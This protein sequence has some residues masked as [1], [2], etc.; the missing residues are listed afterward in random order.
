[1]EVTL[2]VK[3]ELGHSYEETWHQ[4]E[5]YCPGCGKKGVWEEQS[6]GDYYVGP[7]FICPS[8]KA[9]FTIQFDGVRCKCGKPDEI[10]WQDEQRV[11]AIL[12]VMNKEAV[13]HPATAQGCHLES[14]TAT[15]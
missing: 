9:N 7:D 14:E 1:M 12:A 2:K 11:K 3:Y 8:C 6:C 10:N 13:E 15:D 4:G 5:L